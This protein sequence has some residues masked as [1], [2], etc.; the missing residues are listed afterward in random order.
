[1]ELIVD[2]VGFKAF[3]GDIRGTVIDNGEVYSLVELD[4]RYNRI[5]EDGLNWKAGYAIETWK[6]ASSEAVMKLA[7]FN[8]SPKNLIPARLHIKRISNGR[9]TREFVTDVE[10]LKVDSVTGELKSVPVKPIGGKEKVA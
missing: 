10:P 1:M 4:T 5:E 7:K 8:P 9:E 3:K 2:V 6:I